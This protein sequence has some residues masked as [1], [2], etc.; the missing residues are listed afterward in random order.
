MLEDHHELFFP[1]RRYVIIVCIRCSVKVV[2][3]RIINLHVLKHA[4]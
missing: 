4:V 1:V 3:E 2:L